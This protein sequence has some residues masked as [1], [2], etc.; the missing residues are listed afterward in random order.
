MEMENI[1]QKQLIRLGKRE[2]YKIRP[3]LVKL[4]DEDA[5]K[6]VML[7]AKRVRFSEKYAEAFL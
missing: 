1:D 4:R 3:L 6:E 7:R 5:A 2:E